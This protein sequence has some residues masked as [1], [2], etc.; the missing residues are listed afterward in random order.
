MYVRE[1]YKNNREYYLD[2]ARAKRSLSIDFIAKYKEGKSC[3]Y[4]GEGTACCLDFH[5]NGDKSFD[6][7]AA[8]KDGM[9]VKALQKE[10]EK[11]ELVCSNCHRK[12]HAGILGSK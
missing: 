3:K 6:I 9:S 1:H 5:H 8:R 10:I 11:C 7:S 12:I 4:C 2:K